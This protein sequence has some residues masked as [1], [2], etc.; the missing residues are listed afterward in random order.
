MNGQPEAPDE[1]PDEAPDTDGVPPAAAGSE[2]DLIFHGGQIVTVSAL[3]TAKAPEAGAVKDGIITYVGDL[4]G[5]AAWEGPATR[6]RDLRGRALLPGFIDAHGHLGGIGLQA[7]I[8]NLLA[9][10]DGDVTNIESLKAK[11]SDWAGSEVGEDSKWIIGFGYDDAVLTE[12]RHP[13]REDLDQVSTE[14]PVLAT[15]PS[16]HPGAGD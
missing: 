12:H 7:T 16:Y 9:A 11:L 1:S 13:T 15:P 2:A 14:R 10:P 5:A 4:A 3:D 6:R 8:A